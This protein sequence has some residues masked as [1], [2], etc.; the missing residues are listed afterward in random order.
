MKQLAILGST[1]SIGVTTLDIVARFPERFAVVAL[2]AGKNVERLAEQVR[3]FQP[4]VV[5]VGDEV[6]VALLRRLVPEFHGE[7]VFGPQGIE[8][9]ATASR[10][11]LVVS[12]LVG[13]LGLVPTLRAIEAGKDVALANKEV[14]VVAGEVVTR[15]A[16]AAG[17]NL[18]PLD[19]EH[20]AI[21]QALRGHR[22]DEVRRVILTASGG[23]F[24]RRP[25]SELRHVTRDEALQHPTWKMG[26]KITIDSATLMNKGLEVIE[27]RWLFGLSPEQIAVVIH[28]Q[29]I[30]HSMVEYID[31]S[32]LAQ[33]GIPD[34][35]IPISYVLAYPHRLRLDHLPSLNLA[36][37]GSLQFAE[38]DLSKFRCLSLAYRA[39]HAGGT[40]PAVLNAA[41]EVVVAAF[42][43][44]A[45]QF[46][47][48]PAILSAVLDAH[49]PSGAQDLDTLLAAD[50]WARTAAR[51]HVPGDIEHLAAV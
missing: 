28:P 14:L 43:D 33:M 38:P 50:A 29:S 47:D 10:A 41:N 11:E 42:L 36:Q 34:M 13:A 17:V 4:A 1:G 9:V 49:V 48:I 5:A 16:A 24:L 26:N 31:G 7:L 37:A 8:R 25:L 6:S 44:G 15:A 20:N 51:K 18:F 30:V 23:P 45:V 19:S 12:A 46:L 39:L 22:S 3:R 40:V 2:A 32:V 21:F 27:A 35:A